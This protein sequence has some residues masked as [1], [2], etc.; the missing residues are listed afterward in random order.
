MLELCLIT[1]IGER[2]DDNYFNFL[3]QV[4]EG[5]VSMIQLREKNLLFSEFKNRAS[6]LKDFLK[7]WNVPIIIN[8]NPILA[9]QVDADGVHLG[10][11]DMNVKKAMEFL[12]PKKIIGMSIESFEDLEY[13]NSIKNLT[14]VTA[15]AV[16]PSTTKTN[17]RKIWGSLRIR[18]IS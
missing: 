10:K 3:T 5:G 15:S 17:C 13:A 11:D 12:G 16:F 9:K 14:Y 1:N 2:L 4:L 18:K 8:D 6:I 7:S